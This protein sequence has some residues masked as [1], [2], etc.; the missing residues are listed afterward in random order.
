MK[1]RAVR[2]SAT[3]LMSKLNPPSSSLHH[4]SP[5]FTINC[6]AVASLTVPSGQEFHFPNFSQIATRPP[7]KALATPLINWGH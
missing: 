5:L 2:E 4:D 1:M 6:R 3:S 7:W